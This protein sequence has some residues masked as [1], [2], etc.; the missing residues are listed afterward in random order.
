[1]KMRT[2]PY[3]ITPV[4]IWTGVTAPTLYVDAGSYESAIK[5]AMERSTLVKRF[6]LRWT[7]A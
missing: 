2:P 1:M 3:R 4:N 5:I 7:L 6:P